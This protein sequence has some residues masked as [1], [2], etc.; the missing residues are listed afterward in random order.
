[1]LSIGGA[2]LVTNVLLE[3]TRVVAGENHGIWVVIEQRDGHR[4]RSIVIRDNSGEEAFAVPDS[5]PFRIRSADDVTIQ[6]NRQV[7]IA[8]PPVIVDIED[9]CAV[10][11]ADNAPMGLF[12]DGTPGDA[13]S[14][15]RP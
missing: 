2:G 10:T 6:G 4:P 13:C 15:S 3:G 14:G 7:V 11:V 5:A 9:A 12:R 1:V 8:L